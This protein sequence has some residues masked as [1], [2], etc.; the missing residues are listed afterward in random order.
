MP[1]FAVSRSVWFFRTWASAR[2]EV[3]ARDELIDV[4]G[5]L[6]QGQVAYSHGGGELLPV[7]NVGLDGLAVRQPGL[8]RPDARRGGRLIRASEANEQQVRLETI[9]LVGKL[10][11]RLGNLDSLVGDQE[12]EISTTHGR[13]QV[14]AGALEGQ[15]GIIQIFHGGSGRQ[16][17]LAARLDELLNV[18][19]I[20]GGGAAVVGRIVFHA[21][22]RIGI[23]PGLEH[24]AA[25]RLDVGQGF[26]NRRT[27]L[28]RD[29]VQVRQRVR[30]ASRTRL[31][32]GKVG[33]RRQRR[34]ASAN[35]GVALLLVLRQA[36][37]LRLRTRDS[38]GNGQGWR[39]DVLD[40]RRVFL[41]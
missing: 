13:R 22:V 7:I 8:G 28:D 37:Q 41:L 15:F 6:T 5:H 31:S 20:H 33:H 3:V 21:N 32:P 4:P 16:L 27:V 26:P 35:L 40:T 36:K 30:N 9:D 24:V 39:Q 17:Q 11:Q 29:L 38:L 12:V 10:R 34:I 19:A 2:I 1:F 23:H 18:Q 14:A 25:G